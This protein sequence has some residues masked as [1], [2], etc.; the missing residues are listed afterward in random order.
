MSDYPF[1]YQPL[2]IP[3][4]ASSRL[5]RVNALTAGQQRA[6]WEG[7]KALDPALAELMRGDEGLKEIKQHY[8]ADTMFTAEQLN[9]FWNAGLKIIEEKS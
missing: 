9:L 5:V 7:M 8:S 1:R 4:Q 3:I 6:V 2:R